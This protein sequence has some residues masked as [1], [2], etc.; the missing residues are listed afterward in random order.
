MTKGRGKGSTKIIDLT[1]TE[2]PW[3]PAVIAVWNRCQRLASSDPDVWRCPEPE[4][5][6]RLRSALACQLGVP[7]DRLVVTAGV[8]ACAQVIGEAHVTVRLE[9]PGF[10]GIASALRTAGADVTS[11]SWGEMLREQN[12]DQRPATLWL[13]SP[14]RNPDGRSLA[15]DERQVLSRRRVKGAR[16]VVNDIYRWHCVDNKAIPGATLVGSL[17][18]IAGSGCRLGWLVLAHPLDEQVVSRIAARPPALWQRAWAYFL[19]ET[20][21]C[22][23]RRGQIARCL[24]ARDAF[25]SGAESWLPRSA[26]HA[27]GPSVLLS[28]PRLAETD[29]IDRFRRVG[30]RASAGSDFACTVSSAR[31]CFSN[32]SEADARAAA[33][34][35]AALQ[36]HCH[37]GAA[38]PDLSGAR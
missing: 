26:R 24:A 13:T 16:I 3:N 37:D 30:V 19:E 2:P 35:L 36:D 29:L 32:V 25:R 6:G 27:D 38:A 4:G 7:A 21:L 18:K 9:R 11:C 34:R 14:G 23:F 28:F 5:D 20:G 15:E 8:R 22:P 33:H 31:L 10:S 17:S 1:G 12:A